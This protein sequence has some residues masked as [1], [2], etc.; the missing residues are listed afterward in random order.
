MTTYRD[1]PLSTKC[2]GHSLVE[3]LIVLGIMSALLG[4]LMPGLG[5]ARSR[6]TEGRCLNQ[7]RE[8]GLQIHS[9]AHVNADHVAPVIRQRDFS[10]TDPD[11][12]GWDIDVGRWSGLPGGP[13]TIWSCPKESYPYVGNARALG[14]DN[15]RTILG[16][17]RHHAGPSVWN[18]PS[19]LLIA[20][21]AASRQ[22]IFPNGPADP[23]EIGQAQWRQ[24]GDVSDEWKEAWP[25]DTM[26]PVIE[27]HSRGDGPHSRKTSSLLFADGHAGLSSSGREHPQAFL[28]IGDRWWPD[29][30]E[31][32]PYL[33]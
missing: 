31:V 1:T 22:T 16:G 3:L 12:A 25:T 2:S 24:I 27:F 26:R 6:G 28:W 17:R 11:A 7:L 4:V 32:R 21:D 20:Y 33:N 5:H 14:L 10:W 29:K 19:R 9:F 18:E 8:V 15:T 13:R 23:E 30:V